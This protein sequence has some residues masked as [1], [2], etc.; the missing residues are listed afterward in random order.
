MVTLLD[1]RCAWIPRLRMCLTKK[2][3]ILPGPPPKVATNKNLI[4]IPATVCLLMHI[5]N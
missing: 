4:I 3:V 2:T 5:G 1:A